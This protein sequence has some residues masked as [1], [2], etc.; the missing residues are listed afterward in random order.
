MNAKPKNQWTQE[1]AVRLAEL[2]LDP[3]SNGGLTLPLPP[4]ELAGLLLHFDFPAFAVFKDGTP[5][6]LMFLYPC[7]AQDGSFHFASDQRLP[8]PLVEQL[9]SAWLDAF[10]KLRVLAVVP[11]A[12]L[13]RLARRVGFREID[14]EG[15]MILLARQI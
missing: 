10:Q 6:L 4:E 5:T 13:A 12:A 7:D 3:K 8:R 9:M 14:R 2:L 11:R 1:D 15:S